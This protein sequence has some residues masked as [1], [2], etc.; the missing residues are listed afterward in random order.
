METLALNASP[1]IHLT[2]AGLS[3]L[4]E[5]LPFRFVT[6]QEVKAEVVDKGREI[7]PAGSKTIERLIQRARIVVEK[8][9]EKRYIELLATTRGLHSGEVMVLA[10]AKQ[11]G[12]IAVIDDSKARKVAKM[13]AVRFEGT[14][15]L[16]ASAVLQGLMSKFQT[17]AA[18]GEL[19]KHGWGCGPLEFAEITR[20][21]Q[22][23]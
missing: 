18:L 1:L 13:L 3:E 21:I 14:P 10:L 16:L 4:F 15:F 17:I 11:K 5:E 20:K 6:V 23:L 22:E 9:T 12:Y 7:E 19:V 2:K 8:P